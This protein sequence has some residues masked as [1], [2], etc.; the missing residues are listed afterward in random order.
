MEWV[1]EIMP[2]ITWI[3]V[4]AILFLPSSRSKKIKELESRVRELEKKIDKN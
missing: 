2:Y 1:T 4:I 3:I